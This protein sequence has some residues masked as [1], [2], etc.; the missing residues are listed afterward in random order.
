[1]YAKAVRVRAALE[2]TLAR[3]ATT[4]H[5][6]ADQGLRDRSPARLDLAR[7]WMS[8][9]AGSAYLIA[10]GPRGAVDATAG[11]PRSV[12]EPALSAV[13]SSVARGLYT[14]GSRIYLTA[15]HRSPNDT[16]EV[17]VLVDS[18]YLGRAMSSVG[19]NVRLSAKPRWFVGRDR[20][21]LG[22]DSTWTGDGI[23]ARYVE[24]ASTAGRAAP[25]FV[26]RLYLPSGPWAESGSWNGP[27]ELSLDATPRSQFMGFLRGLGGLYPNLFLIFAFATVFGI[28]EGFA[29]RSGR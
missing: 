26:S 18:T 16:V 5:A 3:A 22:T 12:L 13:D 27:I 4:A 29:V 1:G 15:V 28:V 20:M 21:R 7:R 14:R 2:Q 8:A 6:L 19:G 23:Q 11:T 25:W 10:R 24:P 9:D 17:W